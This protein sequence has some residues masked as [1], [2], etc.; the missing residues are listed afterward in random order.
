MLCKLWCL[1]ISDISWLRIM[2]SASLWS[3]P[4]HQHYMDHIHSNCAQNMD[5]HCKSPIKTS[6]GIL[7]DDPQYIDMYHI[8]S[9]L[10]EKSSLKMWNA[11]ALPLH[12]LNHLCDSHVFFSH[13]SS[14]FSFH[15][16]V[17]KEPQ[18]KKY[19][20]MN[21]P[22]RSERMRT[23]T[24]TYII[25]ELLYSQAKRCEDKKSRRNEMK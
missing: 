11:L 22:L 13:V 6:Q 4:E 1:A 20:S 17:P 3:A 25:E 19:L 21:L 12:R 5:G 23:T 14:S 15:F 9:S 16:Y 8:M 24:P 7:H 18:A 10:H 2:M